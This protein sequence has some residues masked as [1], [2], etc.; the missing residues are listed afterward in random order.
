MSRLEEERKAFKKALNTI[1]DYGLAATLGSYP[2]MLKNRV[3][4][5]EE[6]NKSLKNQVDIYC[7]I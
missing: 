7:D 2:G 1:D 4:E 3:E 6:E 5:L